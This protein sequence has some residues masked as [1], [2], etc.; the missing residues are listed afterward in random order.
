MKTIGVKEGLEIHDFEN[1]ADADD[2]TV[3]D[4]ERHGEGD[5]EKAEKDFLQHFRPPGRPPPFLTT[6]PKP[7]P[8]IRAAKRAMRTMSRV[9]GV[10]FQDFIYKIKEAD[11][12]RKEQ[13]TEGGFQK[14]TP[15][16]RE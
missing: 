4:E 12:K 1:E 10:S 15:Y 8:M 5:V 14:E 7:T 9:V 6:I 13:G 11:E 2:E 16:P 3:E